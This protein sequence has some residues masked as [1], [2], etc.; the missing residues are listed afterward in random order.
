MPT[1]YLGAASSQIKVPVS[2]D[3]EQAIKW[4]E[5]LRIPPP[6]DLPAHNAFV[7]IEHFEPSAVGVRKLRA[8]AVPTLNLIIN[9]IYTVPRPRRRCCISSCVARQATLFGF[10]KRE[11]VRQSWAKACNI[12]ASPSDSLYIC[13]N[14]FDPEFVTKFRLLWGFPL[15]K[16][17]VRTKS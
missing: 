5:N 1:E 9:L 4:V 7:C 12:V 11:D 15:F 13:R 14:H 8:N 10:P 2:R 6:L 3:P 16:I 17:R